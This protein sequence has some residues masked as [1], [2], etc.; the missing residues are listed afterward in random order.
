MIKNFIKLS[1]FIVIAC[2]IV[3][4]VGTP[5]YPI[6]PQ[7]TLNNVIK[8]RVIDG[9][10]IIIAVDFKDGDGDL[11][12]ADDE[13]SGLYS[14]Y[15]PDNTTNKFYFNYW[16]NFYV[17]RNN[18]WQLIPFTSSLNFNG[19]FPK[20][21]KEGRK[22]PLKGTLFY[23]FHIPDIAVVSGMINKNDTIK[24]NVQIVDRALNVSNII[25]TNEVVLDLK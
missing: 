24:F 17:K 11:G 16:L 5:E 23:G 7:V 12:L 18:I 10:S 14:F 9:D 21:Y 4:C 25:E 15:N 3:S 1:I 2:F 22:G 20:L 6:T 13:T 19:R 8:K